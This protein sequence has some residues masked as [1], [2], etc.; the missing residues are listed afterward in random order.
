MTPKIESSVAAEAR[1][2]REAKFRRG[3]G[4]AYRQYFS[5]EVWPRRGA[6]LRD[7]TAYVAMAAGVVSAV[8]GGRIGLGH[9][10][11]GVSTVGVMAYSAIAFGF[12]VGGI[13]MALALPQTLLLPLLAHS[14]KCEDREISDA[15]SGRRAR[16]TSFSN[17]VFVY[18]SSAIVH[19]VALVLAFVTLLTLGDHAYLL[20]AGSGAPQH[21]LVGLWIGSVVYAVLTFLKAVITMSQVA[22][23]YATRMSASDGGPTRG[24]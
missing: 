16:K 20:A 13:A 8:V 21:F 22:N 10:S 12:C 5:D 18:S 1:G 23:A 3:P 15:R 6:I 24:G 4:K 7:E 9:V 17:L 19:W 2:T 11:V 14:P